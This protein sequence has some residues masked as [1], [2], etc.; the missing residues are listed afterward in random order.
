MDQFEYWL[1]HGASPPPEGVVDPEHERFYQGPE[2]KAVRSF[3]STALKHFVARGGLA[4]VVEDDKDLRV[5][6]AKVIQW[7][8]L[9][10]RDVLAHLAMATAECAEARAILQRHLITGDGTSCLLE[11]QQAALG[12]GGQD[13]AESLLSRLYNTNPGALDFK[14]MLGQVYTLA[15]RL[16]AIQNLDVDTLLKFFLLRCVRNHSDAS[17]Y[18]AEEKECAENPTMTLRQTYM[19]LLSSYSRRHGQDDPEVQANFAKGGKGGVYCF[20]CG[21]KGH[22]RGDG[23]KCTGSLSKPRQWGEGSDKGGGKGGSPAPGRG[24]SKGAKQRRKWKA[25]LAEAEAQLASAGSP[26]ES[27]R[28]EAPP[29]ASAS[30]GTSH[31]ARADSSAWDAP[32]LVPLSG[33]WDASLAVDSSSELSDVGPGFSFR[34]SLSRRSLA[35]WTLVFVVFLFVAVLVSPA[36]SL[37]QCSVGDPDCTCSPDD[38][39]L[40]SQLS[41]ALFAVWGCVVDAVSFVFWILGSFLSN[42]VFTH[43]AT[44]VSASAATTVDWGLHFVKLVSSLPVADQYKSQLCYL[45]NYSLASEQECG[46][47]CFLCV[48]ASFASASYV[49]VCLDSGCTKMI[50]KKREMFSDYVTVNS[51]RG[52]NCANGEKLPVAGRGTVRFQLQDEKGKV[53]GFVVHNALHV[54]GA[55]QD[56]FSVRSFCASTKGKFQFEEQGGRI[57]AGGSVFK[58]GVAGDLYSMHLRICSNDSA[59]LLGAMDKAPNSAT[60]NN[61][62]ASASTWHSRFMHSSFKTLKTLPQHVRGFLFKDKCKLSEVPD[63]CRCEVCV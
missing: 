24:A 26:A 21:K 7:L 15:S 12:S 43:T 42:C 18:Q 56:L 2:G 44:A 48:N 4:G 27:Q 20:D 45:G 51:S 25:K 53:K 10:N 32:D 63:T 55:T 29:P 36:W 39:S 62:A 47:D 49:Q 19:K 34:R 46:P 50:F 17:D 11:L 41:S 6:N 13:S 14:E 9:G 57:F 61:S 16:L 35:S 37:D 52:I 58:F 60:K 54:P 31:F 3:L 30:G 22:K 33:G 8:L 28:S 23:H 5:L 1:V 40:F 38:P 59:L